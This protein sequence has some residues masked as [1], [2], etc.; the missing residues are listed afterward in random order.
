[1]KA[2][3]DDTS[4]VTQAVGRALVIEGE[5]EPVVCLDPNAGVKILIPFSDAA[6]VGQSGSVTTNNVGGGMTIANPLYAALALKEQGKGR[7]IVP[8]DR[9]MIW[10]NG[11][12]S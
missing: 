5:G 11:P 1:M 4:P 2:R 6:K 12:G 7:V 9:Q 10:K 3:Y 8:Y